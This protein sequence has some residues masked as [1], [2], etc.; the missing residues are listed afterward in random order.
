MNAT[1]KVIQA[2]KEK[3]DNDK[4]LREALLLS[5]KL[6]KANAGNGSLEPKLFDALRW[7][8]TVQEYIS[9]LDFYA[10]WIPNQYGDAWR[11]PDGYNQNQEVY[12]RLC[13]FHW[14]VNQEL[15]G[16]GVVLFQAVQSGEWFREWMTSYARLWGEFL[17]TPESFNENTLN[18]FREFAPQYHIEDSMIVDPHT[19]RL[20][21][22]SPSGWQTFN[23]FFARDLNPGLRPVAEP[24]T[25]STIVSPADCTFKKIYP[26]N[27]HSQI[28]EITVK[29]TH[30]FASI[31]DLLEGSPHKD[32]F[33][34]GTFV[35]YFLGPSDYHRF[36]APVSGQVLESRAVLGNVYLNVVINPETNQFDAPDDAE[37]GY[38]FVQTRGILMLDTTNSPFGNLGKVAVIPVG[39]SQVS[40]V[41]MIAKEG[42]TL[43]K[44]DEFGF[45]LFGGSDIIMLF[46]ADINLSLNDSPV[47]HN[48]GTTVGSC[49]LI[50]KN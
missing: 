38:E 28:D 18:S 47:H 29:Q 25:N 16:N 40:S 49:F 10:K 12:D 3:L 45:F 23:Q 30:K 13:H 42:T 9:Y 48:Y 7:P 33:A 15:Y 26:I 37:D 36:H 43:L 17:D 19:G 22:N 8:L 46:Q 27:E 35:H 1:Y 20:I 44:G 6:A 2:L 24:Y 5:L 4:E 11:T 31:A 50:P 21:P 14:L 39:M 32:D 41:N 34:N